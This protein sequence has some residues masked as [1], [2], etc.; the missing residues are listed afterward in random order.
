M[1]DPKRDAYLIL[2]V[3]GLTA[4]SLVECLLHTGNLTPSEVLACHLEGAAQEAAIDVQIAVDKGESNVQ[5]D[6]DARELRELAQRLK[7]R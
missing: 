4:E 2:G 6:V 7:T 5:R 1:I 3:A